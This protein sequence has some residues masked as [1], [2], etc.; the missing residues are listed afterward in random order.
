MIIDKVATNQ[1]NYRKN[2]YYYN[3]ARDGMFD[4]FNNMINEGMINTLFLPGYIGWSP[5]EGSGIFDPVNNLEGLSIQYYKMTSDLNIDVNDLSSKIKEVD[6]GKSAVLLVNYFGFVD[7]GL[8]EIVNIVREFSG[9]I[10]EDNAHGFFTYHHTLEK[11]S[12]ATFFSLHKMF[13]FNNGGSLLIN[14]NKLKSL[15]FAG[16]RT[17]DIAGDPF[18]Y[19]ITNIA[20]KRK[21]NY[22]KLEKIIMDNNTEEYFL[23]LKKELGENTIPQTFPIV[24]S[25]GNRDKV[26]QLMNDSGYG[27]VSLYHTL[28][29]PLRGSEYK[30]SLELSRRIM[31]LPVHQDVDSDKYLEM[32]ELLIELCLRTNE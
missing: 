32:V 8:N 27:V 29:E 23:P 30:E 9:L 4:L 2:E 16:E 3:S 6:H 12:D 15:P 22:L 14:N 13:P 1:E 19:D 24:I 7:P 5:K 18:E 10:I 28:I 25:K 17:R 26:Y 20:K 21:D 31:N 11:F